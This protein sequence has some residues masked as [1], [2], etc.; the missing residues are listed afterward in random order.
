MVT[1]QAIHIAPAISGHITQTG[2]SS[3]SRVTRP[4]RFVDDQK[5]F[6]LVVAKGR[7]NIGV[8]LTYIESQLKGREWA[9][10]DQYSLAD[11]YLLFFYLSSKR[12]GIPM[13]QAFSSLQLQVG[14][15]RPPKGDRE[16]ACG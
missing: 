16:L 14:I 13:G 3:F 9:A 1:A 8:A 15:G 11:A 4:Q 7:K 10:A 2:Q 5:D 12:A 6:P